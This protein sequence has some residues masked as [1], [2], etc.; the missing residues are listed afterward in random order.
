MKELRSVKRTQEHG[1]LD[2]KQ[3][4]ISI[5]LSSHSDYKCNACSCT[6]VMFAGKSYSMQRVISIRFG[7]PNKAWR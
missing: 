7:F 5:F 1:C 2:V 4:E 3:T 6:V